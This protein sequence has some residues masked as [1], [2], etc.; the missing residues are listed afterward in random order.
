MQPADEDPDL[1]SRRLRGEAAGLAT[2]IADDSKRVFEPCPHTAE[3]EGAR[4]RRDAIEQAIRDTA[5]PQGT[6]GEWTPGLSKEPSSLDGFESAE[7]Y[8][9]DPIDAADDTGRITLSSVQ[10][11]SE[12]TVQPPEATTAEPV[13]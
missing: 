12:E 5:T 11:W 9:I 7:A 6:D 1:T 8:A 3:R 2:R 13:I 4:A 10:S